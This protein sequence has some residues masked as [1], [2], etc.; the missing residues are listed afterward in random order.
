MT[1]VWLDPESGE[2]V[3]RVDRASQT[4]GDAFLALQRP[5]HEGDALGAVGRALV[6]AVG[7]LPPVFAVTG[8]MIWL[9][10]RRAGKRR[11]QGRQARSASDK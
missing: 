6:F 4:R 9:R 10:G 8:A 2:V 1:Q 3:R 11:N 7:W 5:L